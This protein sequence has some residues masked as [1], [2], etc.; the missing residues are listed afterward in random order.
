MRDEDVL[1][2]GLSATDLLP[3]LET[4]GQ[5]VARLRKTLLKLGHGQE[6]FQHRIEEEIGRLS[7]PLPGSAS[8]PGAT[9]A[10]PDTAQQRA[11]MEVDQAVLHL[12]DL[13]QGAAREASAA[14]AAPRSLREGLVLLQIRVRNLQRSFGLEPIPAVGRLF[15]DRC[16]QACGVCEQP[17]LADGE[18]AEEVLPGYRLGD[19]V[20]RP[21][22]VVVN[23][24]NQSGKA[25]SKP[26]GE[27]EGED[28][29]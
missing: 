22:L 4:V 17:G 21:A 10:A 27:P 24:R 3:A 25:P 16:H 28:R 23:R 9:P 18:V 7:R 14:E 8:A 6:L 1:D 13:A 2:A 15:D 20:V 29:S 11:L 19:R 26:P 12:L 5:E